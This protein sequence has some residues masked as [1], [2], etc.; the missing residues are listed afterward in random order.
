MVVRA[1]EFD[2]LAFL[3]QHP[4]QVFTKE[5]LYERIWGMDALSD[6]TTVTVHIKKIRD[7]LSVNEINFD[8][9]ETVWGVGYRFRKEA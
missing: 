3:A 2:L 6:H 4:G 1:R 8:S 9:I 5:H 7:K